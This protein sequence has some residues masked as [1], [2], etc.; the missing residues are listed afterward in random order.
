M[1]RSKKSLSVEQAE[2][3]FPAE[4]L[5]PRGA[6]PLA[7][8]RE[9]A[10][11]CQ[12]CSQ[13]SVRKH[14]L[15]GEGCPNQPPI[16]FIGEG[17]TSTEDIQGKLHVGSAGTLITQVIKALG[18]T[19]EQVYCCNTVCC[20]LDR[21]VQPLAIEYCKEYLFGQIRLV[22]PAVIVTLGGT[23]SYTLIKTKKTFDKLI[24]KWATYEGIPI[25]PT[26]HPNTVLQADGNGAKKFMWEHV[27]AAKEKVAELKRR[28]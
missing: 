11:T 16:M 13:Y 22:A 15:F 2:S 20:R 17:P 28:A 25:M 18:Y 4:V 23:A 1:A 3:L 5:L 9:R 8:L 10:Q 26:L 27:K 6:E 19:R 14:V 24:G 12:N 21:I 7:L